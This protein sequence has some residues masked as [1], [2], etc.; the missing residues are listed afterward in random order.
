MQVHCDVALSVCAM[1]QV[2]DLYRRKHLIHEEEGG[3]HIVLVHN[4]EGDQF[5]F[6]LQG[7]SVL[8]PDDISLM[9][10]VKLNLP[11]V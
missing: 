4:K 11:Q 3:S 6:F 10:L 1:L 2:F 7:A 8:L 9:R 5:F